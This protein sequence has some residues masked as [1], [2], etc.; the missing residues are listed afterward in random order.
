MRQLD[1][2]RD[3][4]AEA[5]AVIGAVHVVVHRLRN[6]DDVDA[7]VVQPLAITQ[8]VVAPDRNQRID[9]DLLQILEHVL[10][11]VVDLVLVCIAEMR[12]HAV[13]RQVARS[14][15]RRVQERAARA[16]RAIDDRL[17][18]LLDV[19]AVVGVLLADEVHQAC[20]AAPDADDPVS[21]A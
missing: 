15:A 9:T 5:D 8:R 3:A 17:G 11:D 1:R 19:L 2:S 16:S 21:F 13:E 18:Q 4:R 20:P 7:F 10:G 12:R 6:R 14:R